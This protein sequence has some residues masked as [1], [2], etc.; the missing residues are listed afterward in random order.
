[1]KEIFLKL[2]ELLQ[3]VAIRINPQTKV[4]V[5]SFDPDKCDRWVKGLHPLP[6]IEQEYHCALT[7]VYQGSQ[8]KSIQRF[9][10]HAYAFPYDFDPNTY[11]LEVSRRVQDKISQA[12]TAIES[13]AAILLENK[14]K[15]EDFP[16]RFS[17]VQQVYELID[18]LQVSVQLHPRKLRL[19]AASD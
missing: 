12:I 3:G 13:G 9:L 2:M 7:S 8:G 10:P 11:P 4:S 15:I 18:K 5:W 16:Y 17:E 1:M 6:E 14:D 19:K